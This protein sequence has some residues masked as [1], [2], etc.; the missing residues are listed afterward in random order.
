MTRRIPLNENVIL[1]ILMDELILLGSEGDSDHL[2]IQSVSDIEEEVDEISSVGESSISQLFYI[3]KYGKTEWKK[4]SRREQDK[5]TSLECFD[6]F[7]PCQIFELA[8][9]HTNAKIC[10]SRPQPPDG[11]PLNAL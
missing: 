4:Q 2:S 10:L 7:V 1:S 8:V 3:G 9:K 11:G 5:K 6:V